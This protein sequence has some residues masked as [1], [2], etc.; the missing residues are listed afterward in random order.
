MNTTID[1]CKTGIA[2]D[3]MWSRYDRNTNTK[4]E[5]VKLIIKRNLIGYVHE[6]TGMHDDD[7][8]QEC[9][10]RDCLCADVP[11][12]FSEENITLCSPYAQRKLDRGL[13][14]PLY[15]EEDLFPCPK[16]KTK[17]ALTAK[18][19]SKGYI[20]DSCADDVE[21]GIDSVLDRGNWHG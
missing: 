19:H 10:E 12:Y 3:L 16:C 14:A 9:G 1:L 13:I 8:C 18:E 6:D 21:A 15:Q 7:A 4:Q 11:E 2:H 5:N 17:E 20:C